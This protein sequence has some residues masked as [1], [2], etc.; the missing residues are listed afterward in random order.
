MQFPP[1]PVLFSCPSSDSFCVTVDSVG[2]VGI[3][4]REEH[5]VSSILPLRLRCYT[6]TPIVSSVP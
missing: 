5:V 1:R 4:A 6:S 2:G 3:F